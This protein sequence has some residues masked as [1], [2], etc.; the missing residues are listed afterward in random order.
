MGMFQ[1]CSANIIGFWAWRS[2]RAYLCTNYA[3]KNVVGYL[4]QGRVKYAMPEN[5]WFWRGAPQAHNSTPN[6]P[7]KVFLNT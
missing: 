6:T 2:K 4:V 7:V 3:S 1:M 5:L